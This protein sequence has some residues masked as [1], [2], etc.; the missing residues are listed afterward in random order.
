MKATAKHLLSTINNSKLNL[1][2]LIDF[3]SLVNAISPI[4]K[5]CKA[6]VNYNFLLPVAT[7]L[8]F[9]DVKLHSHKSGNIRCGNRQIFFLKKRKIYDYLDTM[10]MID[11]NVRSDM[12]GTVLHGRCTRIEKIAPMMI[13]SNQIDDLLNR[14]YS[15]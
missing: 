15:R 5:D 9:F 12:E 4:R 6:R 8:P 11:I 2:F 10:N 7:T 13:I 3:A 14:Y 1:I